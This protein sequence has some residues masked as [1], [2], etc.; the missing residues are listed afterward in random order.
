MLFGFPLASRHFSRSFFRSGAAFRSGLE[1]CSALKFPTKS[2]SSESKSPAVK[3]LGQ[4]EAQQLDVD[5]MSTSGFKLEQLM[6]LAGLS[7]ASGL[8]KGYALP[9]Y[10]RVLVVTGPGNN[11]GD[12]MVAAR[13]LS[14]FG[15]TVTLVVPKEPKQQFFK[16]LILQCKEIGVT[17]LAALP[18]SFQTEYD[19]L[20]DSI[21]GFSFD[22]SGGIREP[23][24]G[25]L[26]AIVQAQTKLPVV[27]VDVPS[28]WHVEKGDIHKIGLQPDTLISLT[29][30]KLCAHFFTGRYH[31]LGG[32]FVPRTIQKKYQLSN[33]HYPGVE[34]AVL[35]ETPS[36]SA[37]ASATKL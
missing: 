19:V 28:G 32:R 6:E 21:F 25:I 31:F 27:S 17:V 29:A 15:Y 9:R 16:D 11:G 34:Q 33:P 30:P 23:Y 35:F 24:A 10:K 8:A 22:A 36:P 1:V 7:V 12:G 18:D 2:M 26:K 13:H 14:H 3:F 5:L 4:K 20:V 37:Q